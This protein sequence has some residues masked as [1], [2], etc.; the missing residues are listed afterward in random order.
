MPPTKSVSSNRRAMYEL[1]H[2]YEH[3]MEAAIRMQTSLYDINVVFE[4]TRAYTDGKTIVLPNVRVFALHDSIT[5]DD[6]AEA[7]AYFMALRGYAWQQAARIVETDISWLSTWRQRVGSFAL[8]MHSALDDIRIEHR[9]GKTA[10]GVSEAMEYMREQWLW[11]RYVRKKLRGHTDIMYELMIGLQCTLKHYENRTE[12][13]LWKALD[14][15]VQSFVERNIDDLDAA[16]DALKMEKRRGTERIAETVERMLK[17]WDEE[18]DLVEPICEFKYEVDADAFAKSPKDAQDRFLNHEFMKGLFKK[19]REDKAK[20]MGKDATEQQMDDMST[21]LTDAMK[22]PLLF[23]TL[24]PRVTTLASVKFGNAYVVRAEPVPAPDDAES[25]A[26]LSKLAPQETRTVVI[27]P[28]DPKLE[29]ALDE[30]M[31]NLINQ[32]MNASSEMQERAKQA[33]EDAHK[34]IDRLPE[35]QKPYLVYTTA[36]DEF[37]TTPEASPGDLKRLRDDVMQHV[38]VVKNRLQVLLRSRTRSRWRGNR[39]EGA[40]LDPQAVAQIALGKSMPHVDLRPFRVKVDQDDLL[41]T[42]CTLL[43]DVS[44]SMAG[45]KLQLARWAT[46]CFAEALDLAGMRF[47]VH[48]F[49]SNEEHWHSVYAKASREDQELY[50]R[51]GALHIETCKSFDEPWRSVAQRLPRIGDLNDANYD[52]DSVQWAAKQLLAQKAQRR[53]MFVLS[54][55]QPATSEPPL[56]RARQQRHLSDV[57]KAMMASGVEMVG[58]GIQDASVRHYYPHHVVIQNASD[59]PKVVM[60]EMEFLLLKSRHNRR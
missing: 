1:I 53:V 50:G 51:F 20:Q 36:N 31:G 9:F 37:V 52:A 7:R 48:A 39:E 55:G 33:V 43:T 14:P 49:T 42:V 47:A 60:S 18:Y 56:Q 32:M 41:S 44:G 10:A 54:D 21:L 16:Y 13:D 11:P 28:P 15:A 38:G 40:M 8:A 23:A 6:V 22:P 59:L 5:D 25:W 58:I 17:R 24:S 35:D 57:V 2:R 30:A 34:H 46:L 12:H 19:L 27:H 3:G 26:E 4:G 45:R 29:Q